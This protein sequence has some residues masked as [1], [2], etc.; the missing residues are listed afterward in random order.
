MAQE[1]ISSLTVAKLKALCVLNDLSASGKKSVLVDRLL[2]SGLERSEIG[3]SAKQAGKEKPSQTKNSNKSKQSSASKTSTTEV[4][5]EEFVMSM[6]DEDT[7]TPLDVDEGSDATKDGA[8]GAQTS[9][10]DDFEADLSAA[11]DDGFDEAEEESDEDVGDDEEF[12]DGEI[13]D[14]EILFGDDDDDEDDDDEVVSSKKNALPAPIPRKSKN[15]DSPA[16]LID[17]IKRPQ[18]AAVLLTA[19]MLAAGGWWYVSNQLEPF[20]GDPLKYG[21]EMNYSIT[22][23]EFIATEGFL[24]PVLEKIESEDDICKIRLEYSGMGQTAITDGKANQLNSQSSLDRL[25]AISMRGG[26]GAEWL[27]VEASNTFDFNKFTVQRHLRSPIPGS[28]ACSDSFVSASGSSHLTSTSWNELR[29]QSTIANQLQW[30]LT[31]DSAYQGNAM[32]YGVG[33]LLGG[34]ETIAPGLAL[35]SQPVEVKQLFGT[36]LIDNGATGSNLGWDWR[37]IGIEKVGGESMWKIAATHHDLEAYCLGSASMTLWIGEDSP[38]AAKQSVDVVISGGDTNRAGCSTTS[39]LLGDYVLPDGELEIH[40]TF[41]RISMT[42]GVKLLDLGKN[43][44]NRPQANEFK[45]NSDELSAWGQ[46]ATHLPDES[47]KRGYNLEQSIPCLDYFSG[48]VTGATAALNDD[49]YI[50]RAIDE[51]D[52]GKTIWN[53][54]WVASDNNAGWVKFSIEGPASEENCKYLNKGAYDE[55][56]SHNRDSIPDVLNITMMEN[57]LMDNSRFPHLTG[58]DKFFTNAGDYHPETRVG[59]LLMV[60]DSGLNSIINNFV[61]SSS[62]ATTVDMSRQWDSQLWANHL[63]LVAD[64]SDGRLIGWNLVQGPL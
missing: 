43:Y 3:L 1:E 37:V 31:L 59:Y 14:A 46:S 11:D 20:T 18:V 27:T 21:D 51:R 54:S 38:W 17:I 34:L 41:V 19:M 57:R 39:K 30:N 47:N 22:E 62:G 7:L 35:L 33:S 26:Q 48:Q 58:D 36:D 10:K 52:N 44:D 56:I 9:D 5:Q 23:G 64:A 12:I 16:T 13:L 24:D 53:I 45:P 15:A 50:W 55:S 49:G 40:H 63:S 2:Q 4:E 6:E 8:G 28:T 32:S 60:P 25:G 61:D 42:R 29:E